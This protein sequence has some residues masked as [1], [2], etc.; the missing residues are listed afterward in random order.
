MLPGQMR[1]MCLSVELT[2]N[3]LKLNQL[4]FAAWTDIIIICYVLRK[5][6]HHFLHRLSAM[7]YDIII[8]I[9]SSGQDVLLLLHRPMNYSRRQDSKLIKFLLLFLFVMRVGETG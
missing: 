7:Q 2:A 1:K 3:N 5:A 4:N 9:S 8:I 6:G